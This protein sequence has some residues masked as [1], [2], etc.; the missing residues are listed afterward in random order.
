[1][2]YLLDSNVLIDANRDYYPINRV[3]EFWC[4][5][6]YR[7]KQRKVKIPHEIYEELTTGKDALSEWIREN[8]SDM[9]S[10]EQTQD[11]LVDKVTRQGYAGDLTDEEILKMGRDPFLIAH[12][13]AVPGGRCVVTTEASKPTKIRANRHIPDVCR[14]LRVPCCNT[15]Q[16]IRA[17]DFST[18]WRSR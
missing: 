5:L 14:D 16:L 2:L 7:G 18:G 11:G 15:F 9:M 8:K 10:N 17:L 13:L 1:M 6:V 12:A 4:W 3:P